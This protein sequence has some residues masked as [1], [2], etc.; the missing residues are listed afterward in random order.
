MM[1]KRVSSSKDQCDFDLDLP[2]S[3]SIGFEINIFIVDYAFYGGSI[4][5][6]YLVISALRYHG[7][8]S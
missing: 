5:I 7:Y 8:A 2:A 3:I 4:L 1:M 6:I